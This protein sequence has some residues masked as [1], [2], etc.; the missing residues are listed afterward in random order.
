MLP[1]ESCSGILRRMYSPVVLDHFK[2]PRNAG[3]L[4]DATAVVEVSNPACGDVLEL[5]V[6]L[7]GDR[8]VAA[9][10]R[11]RGCVTAVACGSALT[12]MSVGKSVAE[13]RRIS[14]VSISQ[15]LGGLPAATFHGSQLACDALEAALAKAMI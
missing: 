13:A 3:E 15:A 9:A 8:I 10:F 7:E 2:N 14:P 12:E 1:G 4:A 11:A 5:S 6:R